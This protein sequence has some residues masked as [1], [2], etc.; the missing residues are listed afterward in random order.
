M[1]SCKYAS[2]VGGPCGYNVDNPVN[3][4]CVIIGKCNKDINN[5]LR[6]FGV[7]FADSALKTEAEL[8]LARAG[9]Y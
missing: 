2:L 1:A 6:A 3:F 9:L 7:G 4:Q 8:L 5:H